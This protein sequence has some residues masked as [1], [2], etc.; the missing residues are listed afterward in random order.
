MQWHLLPETRLFYIVIGIAALLLLGGAW[1]V[2][3]GSRPA[4]HRHAALREYAPMLQQLSAL[5]EEG[6]RYLIETD[7]SRVL[8]QFT[9]TGEAIGFAVTLPSGTPEQVDAVRRA[10]DELGLDA[11]EVAALQPGAGP[12]V[13]ARLAGSE[14]AVAGAGIQAGER[15][16]A[17]LGIPSDA[18]FRG[19]YRGQFDPA[20]LLAT[21]GEQYEHLAARG[22]RPFRRLFAS[23]LRGWR[24]AAKGGSSE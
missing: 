18:G 13:S 7:A 17:A 9:R 19:H 16:L 23:Q 6:A 12:S 1:F 20:S 10:L 14:Q 11:V 22:P 5:M 8:L 4:I 24:E 15:V 2:I 21:Y 3:Q